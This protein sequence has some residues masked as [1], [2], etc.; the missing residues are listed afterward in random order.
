MTTI[1]EKINRRPISPAKEN[2][3]LMTK[4]GLTLPTFDIV[5]TL[6]Q[7]SHVE[8]HSPAELHK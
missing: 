1:F 4:D 8:N 5:F 3:A 7:I 2:E 6:M